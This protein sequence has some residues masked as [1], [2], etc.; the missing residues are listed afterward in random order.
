MIAW[1]IILLV[2]VGVFVVAVVTT[3]SM[4]DKIYEEHVAATT[5][6]PDS[7]E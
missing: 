4:S 5:K 2:V 6:T 3:K 7:A 1:L